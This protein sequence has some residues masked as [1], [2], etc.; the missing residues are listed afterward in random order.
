[1]PGAWQ[2]PVLLFLTTDSFELFS[3]EETMLVVFVL[4]SDFVVA[5]CVVL[6]LQVLEFHNPRSVSLA[7]FSASLK[8]V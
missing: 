8:S 2:I 7:C 5:D 6:P 3:V 1:V 4:S